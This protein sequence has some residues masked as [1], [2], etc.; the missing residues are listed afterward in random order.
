[1]AHSE[2]TK[3]FSNRNPETAPIHVRRY[4]NQSIVKCTSNVMD[5]N[6]T[7]IENACA[8]YNNESIVNCTSKVMNINFTVMENG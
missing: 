1:V 7:V 8:S 6:F 3:A 2:P 5:V 4:N